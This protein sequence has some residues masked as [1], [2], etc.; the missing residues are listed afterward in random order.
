MAA[1]VTPLNKKFIF[2]LIK[3][4][5]QEFS[6][7]SNGSIFEAITGSVLKEFQCILPPLSQQ[8]SIASVLSK[9]ES[10]IEDM[11]A[12]IYKYESRLKY[13]SEELLCGRLRLK[14]VD[15]QN[16]LYKNADDN[17]KEVELNGSNV[18]IPADW[19]VT[20]ISDT[21][22]EN[23]K[24]KLKAGDLSKTGEYPAFNCSKQQKYFAKSYNVE[25]ENIFL[26]TGGTASV[27]YYDGK[28]AYSTD[29]FSIQT[30]EDALIS[31]YLFIFLASNIND[32]DAM[33]YGAGLKHLNKTEFRKYQIFSP[34][35]TEQL[36]I[37]KV[38]EM[39]EA[40]LTSQ[41]EILAKERQ[42]FDFL[43]ENLLSGTYLL[44][45]QD[46]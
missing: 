31:K 8:N 12:L 38:V 32:I 17:W 20:K 41:K 28:A 33:F 30:K 15:G 13:L 25:N 14:E 46:E 6:K 39:Q 10:I 40:I 11:E 21:I 34:K 5:K 16:T 4:N 37:T 3:I 2:N 36:A 27:H 42:K 43:L 44:E 26:S 35:I 24:S 7:L 45:A 19:D 1:I 18:S 29:V 9:Q 22:I 23:N